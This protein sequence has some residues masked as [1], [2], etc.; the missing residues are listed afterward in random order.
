MTLEAL[1][2]LS[3]GFIVRLGDEEGEIIRAGA[4]VWIIW[5][6]SRC[7]NVIDTKSEKWDSFVKYLEAE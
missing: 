4:E 5:P 6:D 3:V 1:A 2:A 7:T